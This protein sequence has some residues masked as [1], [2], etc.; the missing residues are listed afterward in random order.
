MDNEDDV[1]YLLSDNGKETLCEIIIKGI[2]DY[3][4]IEYNYGRE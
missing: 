2:C 4:N 3:F 1:N